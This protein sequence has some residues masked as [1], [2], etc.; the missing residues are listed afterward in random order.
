VETK[1]STFLKWKLSQSTGERRTV[2]IDDLD[3]GYSRAT[4][5]ETFS[6]SGRSSSIEITE[7]AVEVM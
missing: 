6:R 5:F 7:D 2:S 3:A 4:C 1:S